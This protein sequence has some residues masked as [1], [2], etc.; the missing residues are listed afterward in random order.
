MRLTNDYA[1]C[2][3]ANPA[4][5][6]GGIGLLL[7]WLFDYVSGKMHQEIVLELPQCEECHQ[8]GR[9]PRVKHLD[10]DRR[11]AT[12]IVHRSFGR[13]LEAQKPS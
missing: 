2:A 9:G 10:F 11:I 13:A 5:G 12:F 1:V 8:R 6:S 7:T 3:A 4:Q